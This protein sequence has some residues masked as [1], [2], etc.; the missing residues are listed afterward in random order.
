MRTLIIAKILFYRAYGAMRRRYLSVHHLC[1]ELRSMDSLKTELAWTKVK[2]HGSTGSW[3]KSSLTREEV[4]TWLETPEATVETHE[5]VNLSET[6][7]YGLLNNIEL[8]PA[9]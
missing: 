1:N 8:V 4:K 5:T 2:A 6:H 7:V 9:L 3:Y